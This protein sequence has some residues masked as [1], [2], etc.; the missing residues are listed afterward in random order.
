VAKITY[1]LYYIQFDQRGI[2]LNIISV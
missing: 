2:A 1:M